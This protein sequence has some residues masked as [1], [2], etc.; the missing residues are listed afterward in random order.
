MTAQKQGQTGGGSESSGGK[1]KP[2]VKKSPV[3]IFLQQVAKQQEKVDDLKKELAK[4]EG[5]LKKMQDAAK[6]LQAK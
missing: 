5:D 1:R 2:W 3:E 4:E 6:L